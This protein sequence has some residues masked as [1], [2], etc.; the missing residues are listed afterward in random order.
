MGVEY[1]ASLFPVDEKECTFVVESESTETK[2]IVDTQSMRLF[3]EDVHRADANCLCQ[4]KKFILT[5]TVPT[6]SVSVV[7]RHRK[8]SRCESLRC[9]VRR[10]N[11]EQTRRRHSLEAGPPLHGIGSKIETRFDCFALR[12]VWRVKALQKRRA[13]PLA[14]KDSTC[15]FGHGYPV[16]LDTTR[17]C[18][19]VDSSVAT[20]QVAVVTPKASTFKNGI[21]DLAGSAA[22][23]RFKLQRIFAA[24]ETSSLRCKTPSGFGKL[25]LGATGI[26]VQGPLEATPNERLDDA[27]GLETSLTLAAP[28]AGY[29]DPTPSTAL[30]KRAD[31]TLVQKA[32]RTVTFLP[33]LQDE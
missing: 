14:K 15:I 24:R 31:G 21:E 18:S 13:Q 5:A 25:T 7:L 3:A 1:L 8:S 10:Q 20:N 33:I 16:G 11:S 28:A 23:V 27:L 19:S 12:A 9:C 30:G 17:R 2:Y 6:E 32:G 22:L 26:E 29:R 4:K